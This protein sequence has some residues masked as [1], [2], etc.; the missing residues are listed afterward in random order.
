MVLPHA[1]IGSDTITARSY[2]RKNAQ[3]A[4]FHAELLATAASSGTSL[5]PAAVAVCQLEK[6]G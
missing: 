3:A 1:I 6:L 4:A 5:I 2:D